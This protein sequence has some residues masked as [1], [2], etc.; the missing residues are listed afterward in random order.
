MKLPPSVSEP[1]RP[2]TLVGMPFAGKSTAA[3]MLSEHLNLSILSTDARVEELTGLSIPEIFKTRGEI[4]FRKK[5][6]EAL[7]EILNEKGLYILD[8]GGGLPCFYDNMALLNQ[9][10]LTVWLDVPIRELARRSL[11]GYDR[12]ILHALGEDPAQRE[13]FLGNLRFERLPYYGQ[14]HW[15]WKPYAEEESWMRLN[16]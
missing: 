2:I 12:P 9:K 5:E 13:I 16:G 7:L 4:F 8:T 1:S 11:F 15:L 10:T 6:R 3:R 14:A